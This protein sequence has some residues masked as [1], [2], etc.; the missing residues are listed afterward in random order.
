MKDKGKKER[1][2]RFS[3]NRQHFDGRNSSNRE[4]KFVK[5][6]TAARRFQK[7]GFSLKLQEIGILPTLV[8]FPI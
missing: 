5:S 4:A 6:T 2:N 8:Y 7:W 3:S 1:T